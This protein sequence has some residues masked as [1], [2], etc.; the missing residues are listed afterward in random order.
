MSIAA[1]APVEPATT[2]DALNKRLWTTK[3]GREPTIRDAWPDVNVLETLRA[4]T[5]TSRDVVSLSDA[6]GCS[7]TLKA[8]TRAADDAFSGTGPMT[9][10]MLQSWARMNR[11]RIPFDALLIDE[12][13]DLNDN[14]LAFL[15]A[16]DGPRIFIGDGCQAIYG[17]RGA[18]NA[19]RTLHRRATHRFTL[20]RSFRFGPHVAYIANAVLAED[21]APVIVGC[22][23]TRLL[24]PSD[25]SVPD[26]FIA[27]TQARLFLTCL[28]FLRKPRPVH[29]LGRSRDVFL[30]WI[31]IA[32]GDMSDALAGDLRLL[33][34]L[35]AGSTHLIDALEANEGGVGVV[36]TTVHG[37]KGM[38]FD[39][40]A[41]VD[42][43][44]ATGFSKKRKRV[45][46]RASKGASACTSAPHVVA[47]VVVGAS[48]ASVSASS[49]SASASKATVVRPEHRRRIPREV[50]ERN[51]LYVAVTRAKHVL[52]VN[53]SLYQ[54]PLLELLWRRFR[55]G[56]PSPTPCPQPK[57]SCISKTT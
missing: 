11:V 3:K 39:Y 40:V 24:T 41:L 25:A 13:Q 12:A 14:Q 7:N 54:T 22:G 20:T 49:A 34:Q 38:E 32:R 35:P 57:H 6:G 16:H 1:S 44:R 10:G 50:E 5:T 18:A 15:L 27:R 9:H 46:K 36:F 21:D 37:C 51:L 56:E 30:R 26:A 23:D 45:H 4:W 29:L 47:K 31:R 33:E 48:S 28:E 2:L 55:S 52:R 43:F 17:F 19:M 8:A 53:T 42:D